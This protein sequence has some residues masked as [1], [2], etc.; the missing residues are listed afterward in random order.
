M[1]TGQDFLRALLPTSAV[2]WASSMSQ[3]GHG[4]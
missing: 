1:R 4:G 3:L 2:G